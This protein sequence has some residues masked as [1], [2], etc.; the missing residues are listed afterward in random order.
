MHKT[1]A[2]GIVTYQPDEQRLKENIAAAKAQPEAGA[3]LIADNDKGENLGMA[4]GLNKIC[5]Q[6]LDLGYEWVVTLDQD[7][8]MQSGTLSE[9][10]RYTN[11]DDIANSLKIFLSMGWISIFA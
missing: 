3:I 1:F 7:S 11:L 2:I 4:G 8:V 10:A 6:A 9:F 5:Q